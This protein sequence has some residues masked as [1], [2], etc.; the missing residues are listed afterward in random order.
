MEQRRTVWLLSPYHS[1]SHAAWAAGYQRHS[2]HHV[3]LLTMAGRFWKWR[4]QGGAMELAALARAELRKTGVPDLIL[5]TDMVNVP[6]WL[7]LLRGQLPARV[8]ILHYMH[9]NQLTYPLPPGEKPDLTYA[10]INWLSQLAAERVLFNSR[11]HR[12]SWFDALPRL[13]KHFPDYNHLDLIDVV[14][15]KSTVLPV[16]IDCRRILQ[17]PPPLTAHLSIDESVH[18]AE[19][20]LAQTPWP[21]TE[22]P[23]I[24]WNQRWEYDKG[25][26]LFFQWLYRLQAAQV[27]FRLAVAGENFRKIP[28]EFEQAHEQ[29]A[30]EIVHWGYVDSYAAYCALL[31]RADLVVSTALH[32]FFGISVLEAIV[33]GAF[34]LLPNRLSYPELIPTALHPACLYGDEEELLQ[35]SLQRLQMPRPAPPSLQQHVVDRFDWTAVAAQYDRLI[36]EL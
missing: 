24:L 35:M 32:E 34:P 16:G 33:A 27:P 23:L 25:P 17:Q 28:V 10:M 15:Q 7:G 11:Y 8:P 22:R 14:Y 4:M 6:T 31:R 5:T 1:G 21:Q 29:L 3:Q 36:D 9:E 30:E 12:D 26:E 13:L 19:A 20:Q 18:A 2:R